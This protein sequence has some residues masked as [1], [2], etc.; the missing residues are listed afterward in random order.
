M[1]NWPD[2]STIKKGVNAGTLLD[3]SWRRGRQT[4]AIAYMPTYGYIWYVFDGIKDRKNCRLCANQTVDWTLFLFTP[5]VPLQ[6]ICF[7]SLVTWRNHLQPSVQWPK[8]LLCSQYLLYYRTTRR[9]TFCFSTDY[10][11]RIHR[12]YRTTCCFSGDSFTH[13]RWG[14]CWS[15]QWWPLDVCSPWADCCAAS[16]RRWG[17]PILGG[18]RFIIQSVGQFFLGS[19]PG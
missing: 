9:I 4:M 6:V 15:F 12:T 2:N 11:I 18:P 7:L 1:E 10:T 14:S 8:S 5:H 16:P 17:F 19:C 13:P 3:D